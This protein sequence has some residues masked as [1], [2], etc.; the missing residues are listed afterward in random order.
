MHLCD[1]PSADERFVDKKLE[2]DMEE[3]VEEVLI[4]CDS[5]RLPEDELEPQ[6]QEGECVLLATHVDR[7]FSLPPHTFF[8]GFLAFYS[9]QLHHFTPNTITYLAA[10]VSM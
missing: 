6:P 4:V 8:H 1:Y 3:L 5:W 10:F 2:E 9:A 7:G